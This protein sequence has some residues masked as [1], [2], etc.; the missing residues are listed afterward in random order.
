MKSVAESR[1]AEVERVLANVNEDLDELEVIDRGRLLKRAKAGEIIVL[2]V[3]PEDEFHAA[4][5]PH[6]VSI[7]LAALKR[8][9]DEL[10][11]DQQVVAYCRG[12]YCVL[13]S[14][15]VRILRHQGYNA[16]RLGDGIAEWR[17]AGGRLASGQA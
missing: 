8:R 15:A 17:A 11:K 6:A 4:H 3:R 7:P 10:P 1:L 12:P 2:D 5:L 14:E 16:I 13:A 9:I